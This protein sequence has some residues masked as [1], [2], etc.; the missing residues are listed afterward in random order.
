MAGLVAARAMA[1]V[2]G[3]PSNLRVG[4]TLLTIDDFTYLGAFK[5]P[6]TSGGK[7]TSASA[8]G[9]THRYVGGQLRFFTTTY[10]PVDMSQVH[11]FEMSYPGLAASAPYPQAS[12][13]KHWGNIHGDKLVYDGSMGGSDFMYGLFW[14]SIGSRLYWMYGNSY[15]ASY[16]NN[17]CIGV[18]TLND[19]TGVATPLAAYRMGVCK[20]YQF[21]LT[22]I[23]TWFNSAYLGG[24]RLGAGFGG[25]QSA[26]GTG[27]CSLGP[28]L[29]AINPPTGAH[30]STLD[31]TVLMNFPFADHWCRRGDTNYTDLLSGKN[32][33]ETYGYW[34]WTDGVNQTGVWIDTAT[35][36]GFICLTTHGT[37]TI[38]YYGSDIHSTGGPIHAFYIIDPADLALVALGS[39]GADEVIP[40]SMTTIQWPLY[41]YPKPPLNEGQTFDTPQGATFDSTYN[42]LYIYLPESD[43]YYPMIMCYQVS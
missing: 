38:N 17:A 24:K 14:D 42:R 37:G 7:G 2:P 36:S 39:L 41:S 32:P 19:S 18:S 26:G 12:S 28:A 15:N 10:Q 31:K 4:K 16:G 11:V 6:Y 9:L 35:K 1:E 22:H 29:A 27:V 40:D 3:A 30:L 21:G 5:I 8:R 33:T 43:G 34:Q 25:Y 20:P 13:V 23:P